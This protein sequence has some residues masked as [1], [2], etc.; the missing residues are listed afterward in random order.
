[1]D[2][3]IDLNLYYLILRRI[4]GSGVSLLWNGYNWKMVLIISLVTLMSSIS[5][6]HRIQQVCSCNWWKFS[7][8]PCLL[9]ERY[10][11]PFV[12]AQYSCFVCAQTW[13][14]NGLVLVFLNYSHF[15]SMFCEIVYVHQG[16]IWPAPSSWLKGMHFSFLPLL[17]Y[18]VW[19]FF[20]WLDSKTAGF[21]NTYLYKKIKWP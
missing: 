11:S 9:W 17:K 6:V 15:V 3:V 2:S 13:L 14:Q 21:I 19:V 10:G 12:V 18:L 8:H 20:C 4:Q 5:D 7:N 1:M 16:H